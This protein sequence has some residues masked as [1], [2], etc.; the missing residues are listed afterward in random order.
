MSGNRYL[1]LP[2]LATDAGDLGPRTA[3]AQGTRSPLLTAVLEHGA[4]SA[5]FK[6]DSDSVSYRYAYSRANF[7][8]SVS[9][10]Y[11]YCFWSGDGR[12]AEG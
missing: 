3:T 5:G 6:G 10:R 9:Y 4:L 2:L 11:S 7:F 8:C 1:Q 12:L